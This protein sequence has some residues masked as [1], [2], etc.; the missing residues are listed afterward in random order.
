MKKLVI[1]VLVTAL[2]TAGITAVAFSGVLSGFS[3]QSEGVVEVQPT[4]GGLEGLEKLVG[5]DITRVLP[6]NYQL[7]QHKILH[8]KINRARFQPQG[9]ATR[10]ELRWY[11]LTGV[12]IETRLNGQRSYVTVITKGGSVIRSGRMLRIEDV[13]LVIITGPD[14]ARFIELL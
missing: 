12:P 14:T 10:S 7:A 11:D 6:R 13:K 1:V 2:I 8:I 9:S 3:L 5:Q 4:D